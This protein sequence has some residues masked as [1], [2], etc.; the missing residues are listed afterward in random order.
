MKREEEP[1]TPAQKST[2][3]PGAEPIAQNPNPRANEN[4]RVRSEEPGK[5]NADIEDEVG[6]EITDGEDA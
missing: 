3:N 5:E 4:I 1:S 2:A 6:S